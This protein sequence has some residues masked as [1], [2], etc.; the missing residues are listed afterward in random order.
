M[1]DGSLENALKLIQVA[2]DCGASAVK[3]Q[4]H[5][6]ENET[7][8]NAPNPKYFRSEKRYSYF[9]EQHLILNK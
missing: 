3:F 9:K 7:L 6:A 2:K 1:H 5:D 4:L 8:K